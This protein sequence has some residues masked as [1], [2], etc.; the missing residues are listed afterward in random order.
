MRKSLC[1]IIHLVLVYQRSC[2]LRIIEISSDLVPCLVN[3]VMIFKFL[4]LLYLFEIFPVLRAYPNPKG[5]KFDRRRQTTKD[6]FEL[7]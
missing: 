7:R 6:D 4:M 3:L 1:P 2:G 5:G